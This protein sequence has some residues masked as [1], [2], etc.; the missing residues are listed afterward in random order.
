ME[1]KSP[2]SLMNISTIHILT[3]QSPAYD[4]NFK[5][6][7]QSHLDNRTIAWPRGKVLGGSS[8]INFLMQSHAS[9]LDIDNWEKLGNPGWNF[10]SLA[11]YYRKS[12]TLSPPDEETVKALNINY[13]EVDLHGSQGP[14]QTGF[15]R[16]TGP[17]DGVWG[18]T[19]DALGLG[20]RRDPRHGATLGGYPILKY[21]DQKGKRSTTASTYYATVANR[22]N[23]TLIQDALVKRI[24]FDDLDGEPTAS[25]VEYDLE[26]Q[27]FVVHAA[28]EVIL[29]AGTVMSPKILELS[30]IG[31]KATLDKFGIKTVVENDGVGE[32][33]QVGRFPSG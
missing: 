3:C 27:E 19:F 5:T 1:S 33:L 20:V 16:G 22:Q 25:G 29:S 6:I 21:M 32:N 30:G 28:R 23:L 7:P 11:P 18:P 2:L 8:A 26:G 9:K 4:W 24:I 13:L 12:E 15:P 31:S 14:V 10:E 17:A